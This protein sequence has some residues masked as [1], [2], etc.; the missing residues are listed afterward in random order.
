MR[1]YTLCY[2]GHFE[3]VVERMDRLESALREIEDGEIRRPELVV[4]S[5]GEDKQL[6]MV[7]NALVTCEYGDWVGW[8][9]KINAGRGRREVFCRKA[10]DEPRWV[11][12]SES[13]LPVEIH[14]SAIL[15]RSEVMQIVE[16]TIDGNEC[17]EF[18]RLCCLIVSRAVD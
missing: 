3:E 16:F 11:K 1:P 17:S 14:S 9:I 18:I 8:S 6:K 10:D 7:L 2:R 5:N 4:E 13:G 15:D 12:L